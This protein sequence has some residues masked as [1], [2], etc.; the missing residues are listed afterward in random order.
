MSSAKPEPQSARWRS[1]TPWAPPAAAR[2]RSG[3]RATGP[4]ARSAPPMGLTAR[5]TPERKRPSNTGE[6]TPRA[7][8][9]R[10]KPP[11]RTGVSVTPVTL[12]P[13]T[14]TLAVTAKSMHGGIREAARDRGRRTIATGSRDDEGLSTG[15]DPQRR[16]GRPRRSREDHPDRGP[17]AHLGGHR[18]PGPGR[19]RL[20][21][22]RL[23]ARG[24]QAGAV[25]SR[26]P[27]RPS[28]GRGTRST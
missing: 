28:S 15:G 14:V 11:T 9:G 4:F 22:H 19:G 6:E 23:R 25:R 20:H 21:G 26:R 17:P 18:P 2:R 5:S 1:P 13:A 7:R 24:A 12:P 27:W 8:P 10:G 16:P 3:G